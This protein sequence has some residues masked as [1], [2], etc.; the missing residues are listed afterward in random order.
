MYFPELARHELVL[1]SAV[2][3]IWLL[4]F[5]YDRLFYKFLVNRSSSKVGQVTF[6][7]FTLKSEKYHKLRLPALLDGTAYAA[8]LLPKV[9][10]VVYII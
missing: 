5:L 8:V 7:N 4:S 1:N 6:T 10:G 2:A 3:I 9:K